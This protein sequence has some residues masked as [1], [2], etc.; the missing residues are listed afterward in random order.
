M[1]IAKLSATQRAE[2]GKG[3]SRRIRR[4]GLIPAVAY[5]QKKDAVQIAVSPKALKAVLQGVHGQNSVVELAVQGGETF[6]AMVR[7]YSHHPVSR[8]LLHA[9]FYRVDLDKTVDVS[10]PLRSIG[11]AKGVVLGGILQQIYRELPVRCRPTQIPVVLEIDVTELELNASLKVSD[12]KLPEGVAI[13]LPAEQTV[14]TLN[15]PEKVVEEE[16][17]K[18]A[19]APA[20]A[21]G[22]AAPA[23]KAAPAKDDKKKK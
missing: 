5:G 12:L 20:A 14:V 16:T 15:A 2:G 7:Q 3:P 6:N 21:A 11:K 18:A 13:R 8:E 22:K 4:E 1:D 23:A 10:V 9:D 19:A 17:A